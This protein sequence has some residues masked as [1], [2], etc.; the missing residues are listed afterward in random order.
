M[1]TPARNHHFL[2]QSYLAGFT[3][4]G[5]K[6]GRFFVQD[7]KAAR[8]YSTSPRN[9]AAE[10]DFNRVSIPNM[11]PDI[12]EG[13]L[14]GPEGIFA[15]SLKNIRGVASFPTDEDRNA[16]MNLMALIAGN[17]PKTRKT[18]HGT[19]EKIFQQYSAAILSDK[20]LFEAALE[21]GKKKGQQEISGFTF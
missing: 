3:D 20:H 13:A 7:I 15:N 21:R 5:K 16:L 17:S 4:T 12:I 9:V 1:T 2:P 14:S 6:D 8:S 11:P 18:V 10:R 19:Q